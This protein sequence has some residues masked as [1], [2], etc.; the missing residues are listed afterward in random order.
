[1]LALGACG[2][3]AFDS[4][5]DVSTDDSN[6]A[7][8]A[9]TQFLPNGGF[10]DPVVLQAAIGADPQL[11]VDGLTL[12]VTYD[13]TGAAAAISVLLRASTTT[14]FGPPM[15]VAP[16]DTVATENDPA[17]SAD[18]LVLM[19]VTDFSQLW[20][21]RRASTTAAWGV[22]AR[23]VGLETVNVSSCDLSPDGNVIF[24]ESGTAILR[25]ARRNDRSSAFDPPSVISAP[26]VRWMTVSADE[27]LL[28]GNRSD[29][30]ATVWAAR[31]SVT[32][33]FVEQGDVA[34]T[35]ACGTDT[36]D[37]D[38]SPD[39]TQLVLRCGP[40]LHMLTSTRM[41]FGRRAAIGT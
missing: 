2:R 11:S 21:V 4:V 34:I 27:L 41:K 19:Y 18:G 39:G 26:P 20:E 15:I 22:P 38:I 32:E 5:S 40:D 31:G 37:A 10:A 14:A 8:D 24:F 30:V 7:R 16:I 9:S 3:F 35:A 1:M 6:G 13:G 23:A 36:S 29:R 25:R 17:V 33:P 28:F 12:W